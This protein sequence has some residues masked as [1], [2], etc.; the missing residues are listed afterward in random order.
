[1]EKNNNNNKFIRNTTQIEKNLKEDDQ[2]ISVPYKYQVGM[3]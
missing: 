1:M 3:S 2:F